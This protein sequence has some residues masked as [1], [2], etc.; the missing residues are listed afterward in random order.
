MRKSAPDKGSKNPAADNPE[1]KDQADGLE[2]LPAAFF[3]TI[4]L[5]LPFGSVSGRILRSFVRR[6]FSHEIRAP[7]DD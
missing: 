2:E 6:R 7:M 4:G 3:Q 5:I 1:R